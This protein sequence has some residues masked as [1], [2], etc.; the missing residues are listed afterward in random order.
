[1]IQNI[2]INHNERSIPYFIKKFLSKVEI[3]NIL[4]VGCGD[5]YLYKQIKKNKLNINYQGVDINAGIYKI[6]HQKNIKIIKKRE[7]LFKFKKKY[8]AIQLFDVLE[9]DV[10]LYDILMHFSKF[11][12]KYI[13]ISL[14]NEGQLLNRIKFLFC[15]IIDSMDIK[16]QYGKNYNHRH[17]WCINPLSATKTIRTMM[18]KK[19]DIVNEYNV[20]SFSLKLHKRIIQKILIFFLSSNIMMS[21]K[22]IVLKKITK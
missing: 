1:M 2:Y 9:H 7:E 18:K 10:V 11:S 19:F 15:G 14:P 4:D 8:D 3:K 5:G 20:F 13:M 12:K 21:S 22:I 16:I 17:L 6:P